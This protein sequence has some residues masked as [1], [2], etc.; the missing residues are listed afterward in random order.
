[1]TTL[2]PHVFIF[3][4]FRDNEAVMIEEIATNVSNALINT[5]PSSDFDNLVGM[6]AHMEKMKPFLGVDSND[7]RMIGIWG[8]SGIGKSTIARVLFNQHSHEFQLSVFMESIKRR[9]PRPCFDEYSAKLQLQKEFLSQLI[10]Q[11]VV[12]IRH[13]G[14][15]E[16]RLNYKKVFIVLDDVDQ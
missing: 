1:M 8:P 11:K 13:M 12:S 6:R 16:D 3:F 5:V 4:C 15:A 2:L 10:D 14:V 9:Y 7:V